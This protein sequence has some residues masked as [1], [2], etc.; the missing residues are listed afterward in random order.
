MDR[1]QKGVT[2]LVIKRN[3]SVIETITDPGLG[4][5]ERLFS[6]CGNY[7]AHCTHAD[8]STSQACEFSV[9]DLDFELPSD[10]L[11]VGESWK[12]QFS[13]EHITP[14]IVYF[15]S[16]AKQLFA[17]DALPNSGRP[18]IRRNRNSQG[19]SNRQRQGERLANRRM[20][21]RSLES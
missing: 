18:A 16:N 14:I 21:L 12:L 7:T 15:R 2:A 10:E 9:C 8:G 11:P 5:I 20:S 17:T 1:D 4:V 3:G 13:A 19:V 6:A